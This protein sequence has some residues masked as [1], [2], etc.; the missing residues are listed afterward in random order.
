M[1]KYVLSSALDVQIYSRRPYGRS[2][3]TFA[4]SP[5]CPSVLSYCP[6]PGTS[7]SS[8]DV[9]KDVGCVFG[10]QGVWVCYRCF[11]RKVYLW[12]HRITYFWV[13]ILTF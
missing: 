6:L 3:K 11:T 7:L 10:P 12:T 1:C 13:P 8:E 4:L 5:F 9:P 2:V